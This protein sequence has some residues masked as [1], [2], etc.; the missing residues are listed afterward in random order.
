MAALDADH[1]CDARLV[2]APTRLLAS[3]HSIRPCSFCAANLGLTVGSRQL[4]GTFIEEVIAH[5]VQ[6]H[7]FGVSAKQ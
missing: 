6:D 7:G 1:V 2:V 4:R 3:P 5:N